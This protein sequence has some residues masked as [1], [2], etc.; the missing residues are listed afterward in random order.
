[1]KQPSNEIQASSGAGN[2]ILAHISEQTLCPALG[3]TST[4]D[5]AHKM[6]IRSLPHENMNKLCIQFSKHLSAMFATQV[7]QQFSSLASKTYPAEVSQIW[8]Q[9][10][11]APMTYF[12]LLR[13]PTKPQWDRIQTLSTFALVAFYDLDPESARDPK[14]EKRFQFLLWHTEMMYHLTNPELLWFVNE[15]EEKFR[16]K[17]F[18][19]SIKTNSTLSRF[20][21]DLANETSFNAAIKAPSKL[22]NKFK[23]Y[24]LTHW[25]VDYSKNYPFHGSSNKSKRVLKDEWMEIEKKI[26]EWPLIGNMNKYNLYGKENERIMSEESLKSLFGI[27][28]IQEDFLV[29]LKKIKEDSKRERIREYLKNLNHHNIHQVLAVWMKFHSPKRL[30]S[31]DPFCSTALV[32]YIDPSRSQT[33][34]DDFLKYFEKYDKSRVANRIST[35]ASRQRKSETIS[36]E[37]Y[38][39]GDLI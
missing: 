8:D 36:K 1:M 18:Y 24:L 7:R 20:L 3:D 37:V 10:T 32:N 27:S 12:L 33:I 11:L 23:K 29:D 13:N 35:R 26:S 34:F 9:S 30:K 6:E 31:I 17:S 38:G 28:P 5:F 16:D 4:S 22:L 39:E 25:Q 15:K 14:N 2:S 21:L 19:K